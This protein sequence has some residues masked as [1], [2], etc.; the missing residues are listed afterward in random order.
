MQPII[1][2]QDLGKTYRSGKLEVPALR[3]VSFEVDPGEFVAIVGPSG[4][5]KST[6][7]YILGGLTQATSGSVL[8]GGTDF[9]RLTD[10]ER[11]KMRRAKIGFVFQRFNLLPTLSAMGNIEIAHDIANLGAEEKK[12]IDQPLLEHL[13]EMLGIKGRLEHRPNELSGGEQQRVAIA[14]ALISRPAIVLADEPTGNLDTKNS[15]AV[16][17][18]LRTSSRELNQTVLMITHN[19][20]AAQIAD[21]ILHMRDGE[22]THIENGKG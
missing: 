22:I 20:E 8:I 10:A 21:R 17:H 7:F 3:K 16:L 9:A 5:G 11:T 19:P 1:L 15:D 12:P 4:S 2:A 14:R 6:L 18:M 13:T